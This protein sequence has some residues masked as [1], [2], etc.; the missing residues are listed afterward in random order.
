MKLSGASKTFTT[1]PVDSSK[2]ADGAIK[3][4]LRP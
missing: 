3:V 4:L 1:L 2:V